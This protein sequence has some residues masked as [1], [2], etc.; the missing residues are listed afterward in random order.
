M[1]PT[2]ILVLLLMLNSIRLTASAL[3]PT[4]LTI[5]LPVSHFPA[6]GSY[7][8]LPISDAPAYTNNMTKLCVTGYADPGI[9][10]MECECNLSGDVLCRWR[11]VY[12]MLGHWC[13]SACSCPKHHHRPGLRQWLRTWAGKAK[14]V[15]PSDMLSPWMGGDAGEAEDGVLEAQ[16]QPGAG[17]GGGADAGAWRMGSLQ[18]SCQPA[19]TAL[20]PDRRRWKVCKER[21]R[22][23]RRRRTRNGIGGGG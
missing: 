8:P 19:D 18:A 16:V 7:N 12:F 21:R 11:D 20:E 13:E 4:C 10:N 14:P 6:A 1:H 15:Y 9:R 17:E 3:L 23:R 22:P 2:T 5:G